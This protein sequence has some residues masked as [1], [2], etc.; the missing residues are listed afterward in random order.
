M[1]LLEGNTEPWWEGLLEAGFLVRLDTA[2]RCTELTG[3]SSASKSQDFQDHF[4]SKADDFHETAALL[5]VENAKGL[6]KIVEQSS[7]S[8]LRIL[9][10]L[11]LMFYF[12]TRID[13]ALFLSPLEPSVE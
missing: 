6:S 13:K 5:E 11:F 4:G 7:C 10:K 8:C 3:C 2:I 12:L 9:R 1:G